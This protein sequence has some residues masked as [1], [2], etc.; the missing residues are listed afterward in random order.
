MK[1]RIVA[2]ILTLMMLLMVPSFVFADTTIDDDMKLNNFRDTK[3]MELF[4]LRTHYVVFYDDYKDAADRIAAINKQLA[5]MGVEEMTAQEVNQVFS[6]ARNT[7]GVTP[8]A[9]VPTSSKVTFNSY[10]TTV[11]SGSVKYN[12]QRIVATP[13]A[14]VASKLNIEGS[15][16][17]LYNKDFK[18]GTANAVK[19]VAWAVVGSSNPVATVLV[20][21]KDA[22]TGFISGITTSYIVHVN[23]TQYTW[24]LGMNAVFTFVRKD[25]D[26][27]THQVLSLISTKIASGKIGWQY[28][29][30]SYKKTA[31][32]DPIV[33]RDIV[34]GKKDITVTPAN[35]DSNTKAISQFKVNLNPYYA[36]VKEIVLTGPDGKAFIT[37]Y[38]IQPDFPSQLA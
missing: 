36:E 17:Q 32:S 3:I 20:T 2:I 15:K 34:Q 7:G 28:P 11:T 37:L 16:T 26:N 4:D 23:S 1:Q 30:S 14:N 9:N 31:T 27:D 18:A 10:R 12:I 19:S 8:F 35:Y 5:A 38:P 29:T 6:R 25:S 24:T 22:F 13:K 21:I 33:V